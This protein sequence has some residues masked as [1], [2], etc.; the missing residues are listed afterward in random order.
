MEINRYNHVYKPGET[1]QFFMCGDIHLDEPDFQKEVLVK[2]LE[3]AKKRKARI[4][5]PGDVVSGILPSDKKRWSPSSSRDTNDS[6]LNE[7]VD[8]GT[9]LLA[10]YADYIDQIHMGNHEVS[11]LKYHHVDLIRLLVRELN[12][13][14]DV[15]KYGL[16]KHGGYRGWIVHHFRQKGPSGE[17]RGMNFS[18]YYF[19]GSGGSSPITRGLI[20]L[21]RL[22]MDIKS[23]LLWLAHKHQFSYTKYREEGISS[24]G[25]WYNKETFG[26]LTGCYKEFRKKY[27]IAKGYRIDFV[28]E[29]QRS[30]YNLGG[31]FLKLRPNS[32]RIECRISS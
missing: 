25:K 27:D 22:K 17:S 32:T 18:T 26:L 15:K 4:Y 20:D 24:R 3:N 2:E 1:F 10:P 12:K 28:E 14:R 16:M 5:M 23:D 19:H 11:V 30:M 7:I 13:V 8:M 9:E 31:A 6:I 29:R 21:S